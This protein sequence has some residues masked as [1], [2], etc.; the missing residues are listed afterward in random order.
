MYLPKNKIT[1]NLYTN[2]GEYQLNGKEY[3]G[4]YF[5]T[6]FDTYYTGKFPVPFKNGNQR[7]YP[8]NLNTN[9]NFPNPD[10]PVNYSETTTSYLL[11]DA[12]VDSTIVTGKL[13]VVTE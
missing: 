13:V 5:K 2:G 1:P 12:E 9:L 10:Y 11:R 3:V 4:Y 8:I 6:T 7:L